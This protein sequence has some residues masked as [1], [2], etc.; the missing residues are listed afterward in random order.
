A[1]YAA[2]E[3]YFDR[4]GPDGRIMMCGTASVQI[5]LDAGR[6]GDGPGSVPHRWAVAHA[7][8]PVL[9]AAFANSP[10][11]AGRATGWKSTRQ[12]VWSRLDRSRCGPV[13][14]T[15]PRASWARYALDA[16]VMCVRGDDPWQ[17]PAGLTFRDW[18]AGAGTRPAAADDLDY[19]L[20]TLFPPV[21]PRRWLE[22]RMVDAQPG[23]DGWV[24]PLAVAVGL[25]EDETAADRALDATRAS[26]PEHPGPW[27]RAA[28][29]GLADPELRVAASAC[30]GAALGGLGRLGAPPE[31]VA[32]VEQFAERYVA[33]GRCP[34]DDHLAPVACEPTVLEVLR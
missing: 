7:I 8:G 10:H 3:E 29:D 4:S 11:H 22:L 13:G 26:G 23:E 1:R 34:A 16:Q 21:R 15:D 14:G 18:L 24:V 2:M 6:P 9:V 28:R 32:E 19:H 31:V 27:L 33:R 5:N 20:S 25:I 30:F 17:V 12:A